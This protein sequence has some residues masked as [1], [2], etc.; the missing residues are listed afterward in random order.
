MMQNTPPL[1]VTII[2]GYLG[3][4]KTTLVN[5][6]LRHADGRHIV[7]LVNDFGELPIDADLIATADGD[8][9]NLANGCACCSMGGDLFNALVDVLERSPP[10]EYLLIEAS[11]VADPARIAN[12]ARAEP[13]L[14]LDAILALV[15]AE[16]IS[17]LIKD[18]L[19]GPTL[20]QQLATSQL[21]I[22]NKMDLVDNTR[23]AQTTELIRT[24]AP[25]ARLLETSFSK[26]PVDVVLGIHLADTLEGAISETHEMHDNGY[27]RWSKLFE[28]PVSRQEL[29]QALDQMDNSVLRLKGVVQFSDIEQAHVVQ[30]VGTRCTIEPLAQSPPPRQCGLVAIGLKDQLDISMLDNIFDTLANNSK[31]DH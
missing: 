4:G 9:I 2:S 18:R 19:I 16:T 3:S 21:I 30:C 8:T 15:D 10:P 27:A 28:R 5:H 26:V 23:Q 20:E 29:E 22:V 24:I 25:D 14:R 13:D 6:L 7:V 11:G 17:D 12:I 31:A 1:P